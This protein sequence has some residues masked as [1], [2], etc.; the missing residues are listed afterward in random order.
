MVQLL[1]HPSCCQTNLS[2]TPDPA[3]EGP[4]GAWLTGDPTAMSD[5]PKVRHQSSKGENGDGDTAARQAITAPQRAGS[6]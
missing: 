3:L 4:I 2:A 6:K 1:W 5:S